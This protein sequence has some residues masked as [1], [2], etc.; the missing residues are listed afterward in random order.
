MRSLLL[1]L[2]YLSQTLLFVG[3]QSA[4]SPALAEPGTRELL[5][6]SSQESVQRFLN[7]QAKVDFFSLANQFEPQSN[8]FFCGPT[9]AA[10]VLNAF[11]PEKVGAPKD[12]SRF[13]KEEVKYVPEGFDP[14]VGRHTQETVV[15]KGKK[16]R[17]DVFG[18]PV[19][20][21]G[22]EAQ[23]F[24]YQL[25]Q[26]EVLLNEHGL[27]TQLRIADTKIE[28]KVILEEMIGNLSRPNDYVVV[29]YK[30]S[31]VGQKGGGHIS[32]VGAY[33]AASNSFL[34]LDVNP[35]KAAWVWMPAETLIRGMRTFDT[36]E[37]RGYILISTGAIAP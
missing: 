24:G 6:F 16:P 8:A 35:S 11:G 4:V 5:E 9:T 25:R 26:F 37:N 31:E 1:G 21:D 14:A 34:I 27:K 13:S 29:N 18:K 33:D 15:L 30:R 10:I 2:F 7:S 19:R 3:C 17:A 28:D 20:V 22:K 32:P 36:I 23:D 12:K